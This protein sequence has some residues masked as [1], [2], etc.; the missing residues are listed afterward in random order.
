MNFEDLGKSPNTRPSSLSTV[1]ILTF[2]GSGLA[3]LSYLYFTAF[4]SVLADTIHYEDVYDSIPG[5][6][7]SMETL[8][9][10]GRPFFLLL[11]LTNIA[12]L[13]GA[14]FMWNLK[15]IGFHIYTIAQIVGILLPLFFGVAKGIPYGSIFWSGLFVALYALNLKYMQSPSQN[16]EN[17]MDDKTP[18]QN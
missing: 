7:E 16:Q 10:P 8:L 12:S 15:K 5:L 6:K 4:Y 18:S 3:L 11:A 14:Y 9:A 17:D 2:I 1:C 13:C